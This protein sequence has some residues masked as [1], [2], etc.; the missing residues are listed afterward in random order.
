MKRSVLLLTM[1]G[2]MLLAFCGVVVAQQT[3]DGGAQR[4]AENRAGPEEFAPGEVLVKFELGTS[5]Q[6]IAESHRQNDGQVKETIP[7][8]GV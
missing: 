5:G 4:S 1:V 2:A 3:E 7:G 6:D 8:I